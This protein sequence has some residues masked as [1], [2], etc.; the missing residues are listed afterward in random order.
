MAEPL[1]AALVGNIA[2]DEIAAEQIGGAH[3]DETASGRV[4]H[5]VA[6]LRHSTNEP[7]DE[8]ERL[9][10]WVDCAIDLF[11]PA[12]RNAVVTPCLLGCERRL[13][14]HQ[15]VITPSTRT[16]AIAGA[17]IVPS[18]QVDAFQFDDA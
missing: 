18:D 10:M 6:Q 9:A 13:L 3:D 16:I 17:E 15:K 7:R 1:N 8:P 12:T 14:Q 5:K 2:A 11:R 4:D